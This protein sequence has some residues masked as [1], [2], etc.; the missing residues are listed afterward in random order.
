MALP[1]QRQHAV[2]KLGELRMRALAP[3][4]ITAQ[5]LLELPYGAGQGGLR[6]VALLGAAREIERAGD[7]QEISN[8]VHLHRSRPS[9][10]GAAFATR[11][12]RRAGLHY[13]QGAVTVRRFAHW[14]PPLL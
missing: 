11:T 6:D 3:K 13:C 12:A 9:R 5:F 8:L 10:N 7:R 1:Q 4:Q 2:A 14:E